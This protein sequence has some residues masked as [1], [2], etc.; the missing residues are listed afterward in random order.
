MHGQAHA[1]VCGLTASRV[2]C[3]GAQIM[4]ASS[5]RDPLDTPSRSLLAARQAVQWRDL[6]QLHAAAPSSS[7]SS[8]AAGAAALSG[9]ALLPSTKHPFAHAQ[10]RT[11][12]EAHEHVLRMHRPVAIRPQRWGL[13]GQ[14]RG[15][16]RPGQP[17]AH[18]GAG[19]AHGRSRAHS[20]AGAS[21]L[22]SVAS[23]GAMSRR[24]SGLLPDSPMTT[25]GESARPV[26]AAAARRGSVVRM[27]PAVCAVCV[28][29]MG[30]LCAAVEQGALHAIPAGLAQQRRRVLVTAAGARAAAAGRLRQ[31]ERAPR[32]QC[33][34]LSRLRIA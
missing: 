34:T 10:R 21:V 1:P 3:T 31:R 12:A 14:Q 7:S 9:T 30:W 8:A 18:A 22:P 33:M 26:A 19:T 25:A 29:R 4:C 17:N 28:G 2:V 11:G 6:P 27:P 20:S 5:G 23:L 32:G 16:G 24:G 15:R 13:W